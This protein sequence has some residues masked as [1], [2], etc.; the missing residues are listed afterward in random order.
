MIKWLNLQKSLYRLKQTSPNY[1]IFG[2]ILFDMDDINY[3]KFEEF[4]ELISRKGDIFY[5]TNGQVLFGK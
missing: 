4:C 2:D 1:F 5:G 3:E